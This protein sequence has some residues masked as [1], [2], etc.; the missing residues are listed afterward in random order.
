MKLLMCSGKVARWLIRV[1]LNFFVLTTVCHAQSISYSPATLDFSPA[2]PYSVSRD[3][4]VGSTLA[5]AS[6][7][8][9]ANG[10]L[11][12]LSLCTLT[13]KSTV[14]G[15]VLSS[16]IY[17]TGVDGIG[18]SFYVNTQGNLNLIT[19]SGVSTQIRIPAP[20][21]A[22][23]SLP[24]IEAH[25]VVTGPVASG[26]TL[27]SM[28][29]VH[30]NVTGSLGCLWLVGQPAQQNLNTQFSNNTVTPITCSVTTSSVSVT[31]PNV[32]IT[33]LSSVGQTS[34]DTRFDIGLN[35]QSGANVYV[36]LTDATK[37]NNTT[38]LLSLGPSSTAAGVKLRILKSD[39]NPV[40]FGPDS[41]V[42]GTSNQWLVGSSA[43]TN[44]IPLTV[45]YYRAGGALKPGAVNAAATFTMSYQ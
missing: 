20:G 14:V 24:G 35:C 10:F 32:S 8:I 42:A 6:V 38:S 26:Q 4:A 45:Q 9:T 21:S 18:V 41:A 31:L 15:T 5:T 3:T 29:L 23:V 11:S 34:G 19:S 27:S 44:D 13:E 43:S 17:S 30:V 2:G 28:P 25:L 1:L 12:L 7:G 37:P 33:S 36:T 22:S 39:G 40:S 16:G